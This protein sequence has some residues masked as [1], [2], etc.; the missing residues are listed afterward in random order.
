M[1]NPAINEGGPN[2]WS[3]GCPNSRR[4]HKWHDGEKTFTNARMVGGKAGTSRRAHKKAKFS[5]VTSMAQ[6]MQKSSE[7]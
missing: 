1:K 3:D 4:K 6:S 5:G 7:C 2:K